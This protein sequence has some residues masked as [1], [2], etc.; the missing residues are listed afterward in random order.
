MPQFYYKTPIILITKTRDNNIYNELVTIMHH[1]V[2]GKFSFINLSKSHICQCEF[3][4]YEDAIADLEN[5]KKNGRID[6]YQ[7]I[8][9]SFDFMVV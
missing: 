6:N 1:K 3:D 8:P 2:T 4:K 5:Q 7:Y 9:F